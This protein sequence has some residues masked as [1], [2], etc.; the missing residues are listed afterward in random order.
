MILA[1]FTVFPASVESSSPIE[2]DP[3]PDRSI[4][5][6]P[7]FVDERVLPLPPGLH[8]QRARNEIARLVDDVDRAFVI[9]TLPGVARRA[10]LLTNDA[11]Q[12]AGFEQT[13]TLH[14]QHVKVIVW[15]ADREP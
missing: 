14:F 13:E 8:P 1:P 4:G 3:R 12:R 7:R 6:V 2:L 10:N 9:N 5:F 11:L 15:R